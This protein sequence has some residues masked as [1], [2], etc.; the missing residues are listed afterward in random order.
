MSELENSRKLIELGNSIVVTLPPSWLK[1]HKLKPGDSVQVLVDPAGVLVKPFE[2][3]KTPTIKKPQRPGVDRGEYEKRAKELESQLAKAVEA[4]TVALGGMDP[5]AVKTASAD[6]DAIVQM[7]RVV[8]RGLEEWTRFDKEEE[9]F[10]NWRTRDETIRHWKNAP[11][12]C[13]VGH[14]MVFYGPVDRRGLELTG[15]DWMRA[16][17]DQFDYF[18]GFDCKQCNTRYRLT[19]EELEQSSKPKGERSQ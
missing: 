16:P 9:T 3:I 12:E 6:I 15:V 7:Q 5:N 4:K 13:P 19:P 18:I 1:G 11:V 14:P 2:R 10:E 17:L 8:E